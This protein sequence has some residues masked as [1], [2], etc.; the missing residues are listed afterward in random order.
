MDTA[1]KFSRDSAWDLA[2]SIGKLTSMV[3]SSSGVVIIKIMSRAK[4]KSINGVTLISV[5]A[6]RRSLRWNLRAKLERGNG[7]ES[8][9]QNASGR[10]L[11]SGGLRV[12]FD[13]VGCGTGKVLQLDHGNLGVL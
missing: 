9:S 1:W 12:K 6:E 11:A 3:C 2:A 7:D 4:A 8:E 10:V 5:S 13:P